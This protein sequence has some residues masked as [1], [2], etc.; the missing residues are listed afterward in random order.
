MRDSFQVITIHTWLTVTVT[1]EMLWN[2]SIAALILTLLDKTYLL[3]NKPPNNFKFV[4]F[5][6]TK[7]IYI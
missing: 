4:S 2:V 6:Y 5:N 7:I 1:M 3:L